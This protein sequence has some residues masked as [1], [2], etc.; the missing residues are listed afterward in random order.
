MDSISFT[1]LRGISV[2]GIEAHESVS[3]PNGAVW[4]LSF[5]Q[6]AKAILMQALTQNIRYTLTGTDPNATRGFQMKAGD[7]PILVE[8][9]SAVLKFFAETNGAVLQYELGQ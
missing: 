6:G 5:P 9:E 4:P 2:A 1:P 3:L 8:I 7:P